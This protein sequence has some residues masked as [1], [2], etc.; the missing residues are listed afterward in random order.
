MD[1]LIVLESNLEETKEVLHDNLEKLLARQGDLDALAAK[2]SD[3]NV[4]AK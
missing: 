4:A 3:L 2:S 1:K